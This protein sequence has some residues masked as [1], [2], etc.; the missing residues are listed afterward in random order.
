MVS[1]DIWIKIALRRASECE[2]DGWNVAITDVRFANE[3]EAIRH[4]GG[5]VW[6]IDRPGAGLAGQTAE[7][8]SEAGIPDHLVNQVIRNV[9]NL[10]DLEEA[11]DAAFHS[12]PSAKI[13]V[14]TP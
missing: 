4:A 8:S 9:G 3:A 13:E 1:E 7:H 6:R 5:Q 11:V 10:D 2:R 14:S 12:L